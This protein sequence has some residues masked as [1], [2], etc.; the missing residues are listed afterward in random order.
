M[1]RRN[2]PEPK[3]TIE[4]KEK[5]KY[6]RIMINIIFLIHVYFFSLQL[7]IDVDESSLSN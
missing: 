1:S 5:T 3:L 7:G 6:S 2:G 4:K